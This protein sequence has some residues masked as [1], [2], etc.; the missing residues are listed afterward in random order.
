MLLDVN[1]AMHRF[2][3]G[4]GAQHAVTRKT[5]RLCRWYLECSEIV[6]TEANAAIHI[7]QLSIMRA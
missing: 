6:N 7:R 4:K 1:A 5:A 2:N 3:A